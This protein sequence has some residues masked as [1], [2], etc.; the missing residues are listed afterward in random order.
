MS[1]G[2]KQLIINTQERAVSADVNRL[3]SLGTRGWA[4]VLRY[5]LNVTSNDDLDAGSVAVEHTTIES[6]LRAEIF[7]GLMFQPQ[8][9]SLNLLVTPGVIA[10][11]APDGDA[12][13]SAYKIVEDSGITVLGTLVQ[14]VGGASLRVD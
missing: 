6:P 8:I 12:D 13:S 11:I 4:E 7:N 10:A 1:S 3:Q 5:M 14:T 9:G 2:I